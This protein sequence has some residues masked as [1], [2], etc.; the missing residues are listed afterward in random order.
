DLAH[1]VA[2][3]RSPDL[4]RAIAGHVQ[5]CRERAVDDEY[6]LARVVSLTPEDLAL[7]H[8]PPTDDPGQLHQV[9]LALAGEERN[10]GEEVDGLAIRHRDRGSRTP[11]LQPSALRSAS[12]I[13]A[14]RARWSNR[15]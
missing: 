15:S 3:A 11:A 4:H 7:L 5:R 6:E 14:P 9:R 8:L 12:S 1:D 10:R 2:W 13:P